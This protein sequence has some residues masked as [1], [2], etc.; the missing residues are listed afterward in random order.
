VLGRSVGDSYYR[1]RAIVGVASSD[2]SDGL[3]V[4]VTPPVRLELAPLGTYQ[5]RSLA[6][7]HRSLARL[8]AARGDLLAVL[9]LPHHYRPR[10][11]RRYARRLLRNQPAHIHSYAAVYHP[12]L[13]ERRTADGGERSAVRGPQSAVFRPPSAVVCLPPDGA[14]CGVLARRAISRGAWVAPA[15]EPF[16]GVVALDPPLP[17][18]AWQGLQDAQ[19]NVIRHE[20]RGFLALSA[21]TLTHD[22]DLR[23]INVRRLLMLLRRLA[24]G[25][26][27]RYVFEPNGESFR[28]I[29]ARAFERL[30][31]Q[32]YARGAFAGRT[33][34]AAFQVVTDSSLNPPQS[35]DQGRFVVELRV[36]PALPLTFL[37]VSLVQ[38]SDRLL[39]A[40]GR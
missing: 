20:P 4:R 3:A 16:A 22:S 31:G 8:C 10:A 23:P 37:T 5:A 40:E 28:R 9:A 38:T 14:A 1:V 30:L 25:L 32:M 7:V 11:A 15:N 34:S 33:A 26:G 39:V 24:L 35:V 17:S 12:W 2:W 19:V 13:V 21:D 27:A 29:V 6:R 18:R 36:A